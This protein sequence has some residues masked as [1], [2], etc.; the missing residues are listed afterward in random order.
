MSLTTEQL[1]ALCIKHGVHPG[2]ESCAPSSVWAALNELNDMLPVDGI[3]PI[4]RLSIDDSG[5]CAVA[6]LYAPGLPAGEHD[7]FP[8][9]VVAPT[10]AL[11]VEPLT[12]EQLADAWIGAAHIEHATN[13]LTA[14]A[15]AIE[16]AHGIGAQKGGAL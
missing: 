11:A 16:A 8:A 10:P 9:A 2:D 1:R 4:A 7:V 14:F 13:R 5:Q 6:T 15:R 12:D 3:W